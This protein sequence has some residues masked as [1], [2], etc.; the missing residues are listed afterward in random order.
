M[1]IAGIRKRDGGNQRLIPGD[2]AIPY[3]FSHEL[4]RSS[5]ACG[6]D[7]GTPRENALETLVENRIRSAGAYDPRLG[8]ADQQVSQRSRM[9][10][11]GVIDDDERHGL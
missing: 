11:T 2:H 8:Y 1:A 4:A 9:K 5:K 10:N 6:I 7:V 3:G